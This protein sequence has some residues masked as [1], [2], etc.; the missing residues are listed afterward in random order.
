MLQGCKQVSGVFR[1]KQVV[2]AGVQT[3]CR[4]C[5]SR[6]DSCRFPNVSHA[7]GKWLP[8][9][10]CSVPYYSTRQTFNPVT[11]PPFREGRGIHYQQEC[12][13]PE[14]RRRGRR[15]YA[16]DATERV[17]PGTGGHASFRVFSWSR[18]APYSVC[19][20]HSVVFSNRGIQVQ[21]RDGETTGQH[22]EQLESGRHQHNS[23]PY[24]SRSRL[25]R[26]AKTDRL[27]FAF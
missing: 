17:P 25:T 1:P 26:L 6:L 4:V 11:V 22:Q 8:A 2:S 18:A 9:T 10:C 15:R 27:K 3:R 5:A 19:S 24:A 13:F 23:L 12:R 7:H 16:S 14:S 21:G 20:V